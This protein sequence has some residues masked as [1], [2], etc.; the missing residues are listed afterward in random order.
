MFTIILK[1]KNAIIEFP[2][3]SSRK[4]GITVNIEEEKYY[5]KEFDKEH[6][7]YSG[8][9]YNTNNNGEI[10]GMMLIGYRN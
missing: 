10:N 6:H 3:I 2:Y 4:S 8:I 5:E 7:P 9:I 1:N